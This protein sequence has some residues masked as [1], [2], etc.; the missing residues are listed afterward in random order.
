M[1]QVDIAILPTEQICPCMLPVTCLLHR[2][3][4]ILLELLWPFKAY[5]WIPRATSALATTWIF[6][7][8]QWITVFWTE[9]IF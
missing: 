9:D 4:L 3:V 2:L 1:T 6:S 8:L 5:V 7:G